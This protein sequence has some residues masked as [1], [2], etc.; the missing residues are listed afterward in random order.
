MGP[1]PPPG[2]AIAGSTPPSGA[3]WEPGGQRGGGC[4]PRTTARGEGDRGR[5]GEGDLW[6]RGT[7]REAWKFPKKIKRHIW[8]SVLEDLS[9]P[10]I[11]RGGDR[12]PTAN[13]SM[14]QHRLLPGC[15][16][17]RVPLWCD[18]FHDRRRPLPL[19]SLTLPYLAFLATCK[20]PK[21]N[22]PPPSFSGVLRGP[23]HPPPCFLR[24]KPGQPPYFMRFRP[25]AFSTKHM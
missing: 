9:L 13:I 17:K 21:P 22:H 24:C 6:A 18:R 15:L 14:K 1:H 19:P 3:F 16:S 20:S 12:R 11:L 10:E 25:S 8:L 7:R 2:K 23:T 5:G 4:A